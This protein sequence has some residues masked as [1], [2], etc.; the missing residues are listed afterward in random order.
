M[1]GLLRRLTLSL[2]AVLALAVTVLTVTP[3]SAAPAR[4]T[5]NTNTVIFVHGIQGDP[6]KTGH[7]CR[8]TWSA[9]R[10]HFADKGWRGSLLTFGYY[11]GDTN[12]S[13]EFG[14]NRN[15]PIQDVAKAF[16]NYVYD[17][18]SKPSKG[19]KK[20]DVVAHSMG[21][22]VVRAALYHT[23]RGTA[24]FPDGP[25]YIED[26]ATLATPHGGSTNDGF[27]RFLW[28]QC[29]DMRPGSAFLDVLPSTMP[30]SGNGFG[31]DWTTMSAFHDGYV[32]ESSGIAGTAEHEIQYNDDRVG[33]VSFPKLATGTYNSRI[34]NNSTWTSW[35]RYAAPVEMA[36]IA[37]YRPSSA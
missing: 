11:A 22:L 36:R 21:G 10:D 30:N 9:A 2:S 13:H 4:S 7:D 3:A 32:S 33:H 27:C 6:T 24:G 18:F 5:T 12:C 35:N 26:V 25:I 16:A 1:Q 29:K 19:S 28:Q 14:G 8:A 15:T 17:N 23:R 31:T 34:K 20:I 37:V